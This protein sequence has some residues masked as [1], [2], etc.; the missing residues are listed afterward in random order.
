MSDETLLLTVLVCSL[1]SAALLL[2]LLFWPGPDNLIPVDPE[3][4][5]VCRQIAPPEG[6]SL[7]MRELAAVIERSKGELP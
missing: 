3:E 7:T 5:V 6:P 2:A 1:P 4:P